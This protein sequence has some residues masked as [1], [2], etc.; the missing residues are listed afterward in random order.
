MLATVNRVLLDGDRPI[1]LVTGEV[2]DRET[3]YAGE[4]PDG[5]R[6]EDTDSVRRPQA[7]VA[8]VVDPERRKQGVGRAAI[9][10]WMAHSDLDLAGSFVA[11]IEP[12]NEGS[13]AL[14]ASL[15]FRP[16]SVEPDWEGMLTYVCGRR[17]D[18]ASV[19]A[20]G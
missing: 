20:S 16:V 3:R 2:Y 17:E 11:G 4:G 5:P 6:F 14:F 9:A 7:G 1:A 18:A 19:R 13:R 8:V 12:E 10:A 15:G